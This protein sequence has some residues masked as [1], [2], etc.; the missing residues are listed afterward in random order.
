MKRSAQILLHLGILLS[1]IMSEG[2]LLLAG[3]FMKDFDSLQ[4]HWLPWIALTFVLYLF[5]EWLSERTLSMNLLMILHTLMISGG[6]LAGLFLIRMTPSSMSASF[7]GMLA[8][9]IPV[10][11]GS[12]FVFFPESL[13]ALVLGLD[14][15]VIFF[16]FYL[17]LDLVGVLLPQPNLEQAFFLSMAAVLAILVLV[18]TSS[19]MEGSGVSIRNLLPILGFIAL[20][21]F[22][23]VLAAVL[24][25]GQVKSITDF[26]VL[27]LKTIVMG[28]FWVMGK[29]SDLIS[30]LVTW[31]IRLL[32]DQEAQTFE[33]E[34]AAALSGEME[35]E[36]EIAS[37]PPALIIGILAV[38]LLAALLVLFRHFRGR[39]WRRKNARRK[40]GSVQKLRPSSPV[41]PGLAGRA[42]RAV[43]F[44]LLLFRKR[45]TPSGIACRLERHGRKHGLPRRAGESVPS[46]LRRL[47][48]CPALSLDE[49]TADAIQELASLLELEYYSGQTFGNQEDLYSLLRSFS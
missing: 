44:R 36:E 30:W 45:K 14:F 10:A 24:V 2:F 4:I 12:Y 15:L 18:R 29:F 19:D 22:L 3:C 40:N 13:R 43:Y 34:P 27:I 11:L 17:F 48:S 28:V 46:Y 16:I 32:P 41:L 38:L 8:L 37:L 5:G 31:L 21:L 9:A 47:S 25:S 23:A 6:A 26:F 1:L 35:M 42:L 7:A 20:L 39:T 49:K 33:M